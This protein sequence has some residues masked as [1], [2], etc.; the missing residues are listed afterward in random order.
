MRFTIPILVLAAA[1]GQKKEPLGAQGQQGDLMA[2]IPVPE[3]TLLEAQDRPL[4]RKDLLGKVW[5]CSFIYS[6]CPTHCVSMAMEM[7]ELQE[8]FEKEKDFRIVAVTVD[9]AFDTPKVLRGFAKSYDADP[10]RWFFLTGK[11]ED[12][13]KLAHEGLKIQ[14]HPD[15]P[16]IHSQHFVLIDR[17]GVARGYYAQGDPDRM[18]KLREHIRT[19]LAE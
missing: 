18:E 7:A 5:V 9:P 15:E 12:I 6:R 13:R 10:E 4:G 16:L 19:L 2:N 8:D 1:C 14:W 17:K 3:F 11:R